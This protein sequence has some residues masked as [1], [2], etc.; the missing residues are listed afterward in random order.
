MK[1]SVLSLKD[2]IHILKNAS[3][4]GFCVKFERNTMQHWFPYF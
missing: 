4:E 3:Y 1:D 2:N